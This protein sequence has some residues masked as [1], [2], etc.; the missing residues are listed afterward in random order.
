MLH[1]FLRRRGEVVDPANLVA[2][3]SGGKALALRQQRLDG[4]LLRVGQLA[5][6]LAENLDAVVLIGVVR[7]RNDNACVGLILCAQPCH[8]GR[9]DDPQQHHVDPHGGQPGRHR[10]LQH[11]GGGARILADDHLAARTPVRLCQR[12]GGRLADAHCKFT[13]QLHAGDVAYAVG[14]KQF[15][16]MFNHSFPD[17]RGCRIRWQNT[18]LEVS[19]SRESWA[20]DAAGNSIPRCS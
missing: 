18:H 17:R 10:L 7:R 12:Q 6:A 14:S 4:L 13:G 2:R 8:G 20:A 15:C 3:L 1:I 5:A 9:G 11:V 19:P 16:H